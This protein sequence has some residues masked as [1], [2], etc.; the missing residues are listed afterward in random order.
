MQALISEQEQLVRH[1]I[2]YPVIPTIFTM[3]NSLSDLFKS[4]SGF[5]QK[6]MSE[7]KVT[8]RQIPPNM[9][10]R[11]MV[12]PTMATRR[13]SEKQNVQMAWST[14]QFGLENSLQNKNY[15]I[16]IVYLYILYCIIME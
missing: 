6:T 13:I 7:E 8:I 3:Y 9:I 14:V 5:K 4:S 16:V 12:L 2:T 11:T 10:H 15:C 1:H